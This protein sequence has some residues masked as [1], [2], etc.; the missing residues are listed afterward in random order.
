[1]PKTPRNDHF[2]Q[3]F[4][5]QQETELVEHILDLERRFYGITPLDARRF[6]F[7]LAEHLQLDHP[8]NKTAKLIGND[9]LS[10]FKKR[11]T[12][13]S[14][15]APEP[16]S[17]ARAAGF[18]KLQVQKFFDV[19]R[20]VLEANNIQPDQIYN[21][22][23]TGINSVP[24]PR[25]ILAEKC[26]KQVGRIV[27]TER[28]F[29]VT[30]VCGISA[31]GSYTPPFFLFPRQRM[32][33]LFMRGCSPGAVG[34]AN[35]SGWMDPDHFVKYLDHFINHMKSGP[36]KKILLILDNH[37][38]HRTL[39][40]IT[41]ARQT[42]IIMV[43]LPPHTSH[44][45]QPLDCTVFGSLKH[46]YARECDLWH[47]N[48]P[49]SR[50]SLYDIV[51]MFSRAFLHVATMEKAVKGFQTTGIYPF[52]N[53]IFSDECFRP[54]EVTDVLVNEE[55]ESPIPANNFP[56]DHQPETENLF[57]EPQP[58]CSYT[59][60]KDIILKVSPKPKSDARKNTNQNSQKKVSRAQHAEELTS[61]PFKDQLI[62]KEAEKKQSTKTVKR[63]L[64]ENG[65]G[66]LH[67]RKR[68]N[69]GK[70]SRRSFK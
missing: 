2:K 17:I 47:T 38:S 18:N 64:T 10:G 44:R 16:T 39:A 48:N 19:L 54:A 62:A 26:K 49:G 50:V 57:K 52:N 15:R 4:T 13:F 35:G 32:N 20:S 51:G 24:V 61:S 58:S 60:F 7:E 70:E 67:T 12:Q 65:E 46:Q 34:Y 63:K 1:M 56:D 69:R 59:S 41:K 22:N 66:K 33:T 30:A 25:K 3:V 68:K 31:A 55:T 14:I 21:I 6:A 27:S 9:W 23:E 28:G 40:A 29:N 11:N 36:N 42:N 5:V 8:F 45:L 43:S 53:E 37:N